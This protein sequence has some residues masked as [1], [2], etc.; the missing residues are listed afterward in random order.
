MSSFT[1]PRWSKDG[2]RVFFG[3]KEQ[4][5]EISAADSLKANV[6]VWHYKDTEIQSVKQDAKRNR[7]QFASKE[8]FDLLTSKPE[9]ALWL[10][11]GR[12]VQFTL[13]SDIYEVFE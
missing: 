12:N 5:K 2:A 7:V 3:I 13:G 10:A 11:L 1:A 4:E 9:S 8:Y 6:D